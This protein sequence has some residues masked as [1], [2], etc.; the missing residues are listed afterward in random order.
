MKEE[1]LYS[2]IKAA[3]RAVGSARAGDPGDVTGFRLLVRKAAWRQGWDAGARAMGP[4]HE[5]T[6]EIWSDAI[7]RCLRERGSAWIPRM[8]EPIYIDRPIVLR[9]G[10]RL[11]VHPE[12][13]IRLHP[14]SAGTC[15]VR[16]AGIVFAQ[17]R[18]V[19]LN[20]G[21][22]EDIV[23]EGGIWNDQINGGK[24][25]GGA[26]DRAGSMPGSH[27]IF[28]LHNVA[29]LLVRNVRFRDCSPFAVQL[30]N[31]TDFVVEDIAFDETADGIHIEGPAA[32]GVIRRIAGK[33]NDDA[34]ALNAWDWDNSS[35]TFGPITD[36]LVEDVEVRPG[37]TWSE[38]RLLPGTKVFPGGAT[39][40]CD[41]RRCIFR[42]IRGLHTFKMY[43]QPN[44]SKTEEDFA[45]PIGRM[46]DLFFSDI[47]V[48]GILRA[49]YYDTYSDGVFDICADVERIS[50]RNVRLDYPLGDAERAPYLVSVGP[51]SL[52]WARG[53][54][55]EDGWVEVFNP[56]ASPV[57]KGLV[58]SGVVMPAAG[59]SGAAAPCRD[60][61][62]L[63]H[64]RRLT[65]NPDFPR[66][67]PRGGTGN[68]RIVEPRLE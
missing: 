67:Q 51:K 16:N 6:G 14:D 7:D 58:V 63:F 12:T 9:G 24:G 46:A 23:I 48:N 50:I 33:T 26:F 39:V 57:V 13:E 27:G 42:N 56:N 30:G 41:I 61:A 19:E 66:T 22:D 68:G 31:A 60:A 65:L 8:A 36:V 45:D 28:L 62:L 49:D 43:D 2:E 59:G 52:T 38:L 55:P 53:L 40:D 17:D 32:R 3:T 11:S 34:V 29:R 15:M 37:Y 64:E 1:D 47:T 18:P 10:Q 5:V 44:L 4:E 35:L 54:K 21:A 25:R 20:A